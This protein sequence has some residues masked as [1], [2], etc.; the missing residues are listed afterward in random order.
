FVDRFEREARSAAKV[1]HPHVVAVHD[2]GVDA[3]PE[4][5]LVYLVM[6]LVDGGTLRDLITER[7]TLDT[8][9]A[10]AI[11]EPVLGALAAAHRA[12]LVHRDVKPENVL[13]GDDG[14]VKVADFGLAHAVEASSQDT[15]GQLMATV[16]YVAPELV[17][18]G[19]ADPR[20]DVYSA[21][22][23]LYEMLTGRV[24][25]VGERSVDVA[26]QHVERDVP[27]PSRLVPGLPP[28]LDDLVVRATRRDPGA[29]PVDAGAFL[30]ELRAVRQD[31]GLDA[32]APTQQ[33]TRT[34]GHATVT[35][36]RAEEY[37]YEP[38]AVRPEPRRRTGMV[39]AAMVVA[40]GLLAAVGGWWL[41]AGRYTEA[42]SLLS[43]SKQQAE[44]TALRL[45]FEID[46]D[47]GK[48]SEKVP[49]DVVLEQ[50]PGPRHRII[51]GDVITLTLSLG[52]ERYKIPD[53]IGDE[54]ADAK[55][56]LAERKLQIKIT[57]AYSDTVPQNS[58]VA[59]SPKPGTTVR[60]NTRVTL[61]VSKGEAPI[62]VPDVTGDDVEDAQEELEELGLVVTIKRQP[63]MEVDR[64]HVISQDPKPGTGVGDAA[65]V[66]LLV[67]DGPPQVEI[68]D[69]VDKPVEEAEKILKQAGFEVEI[70][71]FPGGDD[72][73]YEQSP[74]AGE[75]ADKG[76]TVSILVT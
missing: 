57:E 20:A 72:V 7:G 67:S 48:Y 35:L 62:K 14:P 74:A 64:D 51:K 4:G 39:I 15:D 9:L 76:S 49:K 31:L 2:Q 73:V 33:V 66:T 36:P 37:D 5:A 41:G 38:M 69:V 60:P 65:T 56:K 32:T 71:N 24:P 52:K 8:A 27:P 25:Y 50:S 68:P 44:S 63:N 53:V 22:I 29:R 21:G 12:G 13:I 47:E 70:Y 23:V 3:N 75:K 54:L 10:C 34:V 11:M 42:P 46:Y 30:A 6:E 45:G 40:L 59:I 28:Q 55:E 58:V 18:E 26:Y 61:V 17:S 1:H 19:R 16:A 43:M